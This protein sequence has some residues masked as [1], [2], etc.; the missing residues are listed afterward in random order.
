MVRSSSGDVIRFVAPAT[1]PIYGYFKT[2][3]EDNKVTHVEMFVSTAWWY[4]LLVLLF[5]FLLMASGVY[6]FQ[7]DTFLGTLLV[8]VGMFEFGIGWFS[9]KILQKKWE[10]YLSQEMH[11]ATFF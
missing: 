9:S 1:S 10:L 8:I 6:V 2:T 3:S 5:S 7:S 11:L 4:F